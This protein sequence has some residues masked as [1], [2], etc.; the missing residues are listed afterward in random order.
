MDDDQGT[1][2]P[3]GP[4][5]ESSSKRFGLP[6]A[7]GKRLSDACETSLGDVVSPS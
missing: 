6:V 7:T 4:D 5:V 2:S 1:D 3:L